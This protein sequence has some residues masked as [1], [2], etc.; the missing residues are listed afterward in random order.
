LSGTRTLFTYELPLRAGFF[1]I[2]NVVPIGL[3][4]KQAEVSEHLS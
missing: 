2:L 3:G 1:W 4:V